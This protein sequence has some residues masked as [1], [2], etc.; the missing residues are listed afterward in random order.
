MPFDPITTAE[1]AVGNFFKN[2]VA[3][4]I[5]DNLDYLY[6]IIGAVESA[7]VKNGSFEIDSDSDGKPDS[8]VWEAIG[9][10]VGEISTTAPMHG[11]YAMKF[12]S[13]GSGGGKLTSDFLPIGGYTVDAIQGRNEMSVLS[14]RGLRVG[15][16][17]KAKITIKGFRYDKI[18]PTADIILFDGEL[19]TAEIKYLHIFKV[20][21]YT[22]WIQIEIQGAYDTDAGD[23]YIDDVSMSPYIQWKWLAQ[24]F[25]VP[26]ATRSAG[27]WQLK[28]YGYLVLPCIPDC[29]ILLTFTASMK[30]LSSA[31]IGY[32]KFVCG[33]NASNEPS[34]ISETYEDKIITLRI[35][36][37]QA[38]ALNPQNI[39][40]EM[41]L[42]NTVG[43]VYGKVVAGDAQGEIEYYRSA[44]LA[45]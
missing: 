27:D 13:A 42:K 44:N 38:E 10:G 23:C 18:T 26:E 43:T 40:I 7:G 34:S 11:K 20:S 31:W 14:W 1:I 22:R 15:L 6:G 5:K 16:G 33:A 39:P 45:L 17:I 3:T 35:A 30:V 29:P 2:E 37:P 19:Q 24:S 28:D 41:W 32:M 12:T 8:W 21:D 36:N 25:A 4:K 9:T